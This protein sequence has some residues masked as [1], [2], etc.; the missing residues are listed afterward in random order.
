MF[1]EFT[2]YVAC[3]VDNFG[4]FIILERLS[5]VKDK[6]LTR[7]RCQSVAFS[8]QIMDVDQDDT[9]SLDF[10]K[11]SFLSLLSRV[12][13]IEAGDFAEWVVQHCSS[14]HT[15][16]DTKPNINETNTTAEEKR[17]KKIIGDIKK[18]V[19]LDGILPSENICHP[20]G[21]VIVATFR[22]YVSHC[23]LRRPHALPGPS[24][25]LAGEGIH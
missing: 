21:K 16:G 19:P 25:P 15:N 10:A 14:F 11:S 17:I 8:V 5:P 20:E 9:Y 2:F 18:R 22:I 7:L 24:P 3:C 6:L 13:P 12:E 4:Y 23:H 1:F